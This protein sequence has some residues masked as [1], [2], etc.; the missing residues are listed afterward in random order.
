M[1][2]PDVPRKGPLTPEAQQRAHNQAV[3][4]GLGAGRD[5]LLRPAGI[6]RAG[7]ARTPTAGGGPA[8]IASFYDTTTGPTATVAHAGTMTAGWSFGDTNP[9]TVSSGNVRL[10]LS[11]WYVIEAWGVFKGVAAGDQVKVEASSARIPVPCVGTAGYI[12]LTPTVAQATTV[13]FYIPFGDPP[14]DILL[15]GSGTAA[16]YLDELELVVTVMAGLNLG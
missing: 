4:P 2:T 14:V 16:G 7:Q 11:G 15:V 5:R 10:L 6:L 8:A 9:C 13:P 12:P 1:T 3:G